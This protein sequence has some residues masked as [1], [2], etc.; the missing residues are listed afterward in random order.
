MKIKFKTNPNNKKEA[1]FV[2]IH[3]DIRPFLH[4]DSPKHDRSY[5]TKA[6]I[7]SNRRDNAKG[8]IGGTLDKDEDIIDG[9][10]REID[11][12]YGFDIELEKLIPLCSYES[13]KIVS[14]LFEYH[15]D[16]IEFF[17]ILAQINDNFSNFFN[18]HTKFLSKYSADTN[19]E[20]RSREEFGISHFFS[21]IR[22]V[23]AIYLSDRKYDME[24]LFENKFVGSGLQELKIFLEKY[25]LL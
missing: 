8:F 11:E 24:N 6:F 1:V 25:E 10:K 3:S 7:V 15:V 14:H 20:E 22:N 4:Y 23:E 12:E 16:E 18:N 21:E 9:L 19:I 2:L 17:K 13:K 5:R